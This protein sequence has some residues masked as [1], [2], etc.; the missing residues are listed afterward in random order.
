MDI[1]KIIRASL[2]RLKYNYFSS[3][4][5]KKYL[6][7]KLFKFLNQK[8]FEIFLIK[9]KKTFKLHKNDFFNQDTKLYFPADSF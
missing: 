2:G 6:R 7:G 3:N 5:P 8:N 9:D 4:H 1:K